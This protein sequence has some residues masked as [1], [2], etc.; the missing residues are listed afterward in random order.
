MKALLRKKILEMRAGLTEAEISSLSR[1]VFNNIVDAG[2]LNNKNS[3]MTYLDFR[4]EV[5]TGDILS[6]ALAN[7]LTLSIPV[8]IPE[9]KELIAARIAA[10]EELAVGHYGI[11]EPKP[12]KTRITDC[13]TLDIVFTPGA[14]FD[15]HGNRIGYGAGYYDKFFK[16]LGKDVLKVALAYSFQVVDQ[17][18][19]DEYDIPVDFIVTEKEVIKRKNLGR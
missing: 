6:Y 18:P 3:I 5:R 11:R 17:V 16:R 12:E 19:A 7:N 8:C 15:D 10:L 4:N 2:L 1:S 9:T 13:N 14:V